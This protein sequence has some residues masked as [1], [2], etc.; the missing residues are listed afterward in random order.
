MARNGRTGAR[1]RTG[2]GWGRVLVAVYG[3]FALS[4]T[5]RSTVQLLTKFDEAPGAYLLSALAA[6]VYIA[7]TVGLAI[8]SP[9]ARAVAWC[10]VIV[11]LVGVVTVGTVSVLREE[12][13]ADHTVWSSYG[14]GYGYL[15]LLLPFAGL[16]WL[17][18]TRPLRPGAAPV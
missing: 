11:E 7:A 4:A 10:A 17:W 13:F 8:D 1:T 3:V 5:G 12:W 15:P 6:V 14:V 9:R 2:A 16:A 18:H